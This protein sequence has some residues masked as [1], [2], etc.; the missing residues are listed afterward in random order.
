[1]QK[2]AL[3]L[4]VLFLMACSNSNH[5]D[6]SEIEQLKQHLDSIKFG[7]IRPLLDKNTP[8]E[9]IRRIDSVSIIDSIHKT[10]QVIY[11]NTNKGTRE[12]VWEHK[13]K[14]SPGY[15]YITSIESLDKK[16]ETNP[17]IILIAE[18]FPAIAA[19][20]DSTHSLVITIETH[21]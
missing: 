5:T 2:S 1:M 9:T 12:F 11:Y 7:N 13:K 21:P 17:G 20:K 14:L 15:F 10:Y 8:G 3:F 4:I 19:S 18:N 6:N 16:G